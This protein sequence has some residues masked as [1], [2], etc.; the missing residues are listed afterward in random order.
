MDMKKIKLI[1]ALIGGTVGL[2][3]LI[4]V[5]R[6]LVETNNAGYFQVKQTVGTG[7]MSV[8]NSPGMYLKLFATI[9]TYQVSD[10]HYFSAAEKEGD[11]A[12]E[13]EPIKV[14]FNDGGTAEVSG[15]IKYR[16]PTIEQA[17]LRLHQ[18]YKSYSAVRHDLIR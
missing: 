5:G 6:G 12:I 9:T 11:R 16:L 14:R 10:M 7:S 8:V 13:S 3:L 4:S 15:S 1:T 18:D 17:Q 2:L